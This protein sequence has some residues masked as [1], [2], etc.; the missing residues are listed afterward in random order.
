MRLFR[1]KVKTGCSEVNM[2]LLHVG[3]DHIH[4]KFGPL[5]RRKSKIVMIKGDV[6]GIVILGGY[7]HRYVQLGPGVGEV[8]L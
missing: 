6:V 3:N 7:I 4:L 1:F 8:I 2:F 5:L